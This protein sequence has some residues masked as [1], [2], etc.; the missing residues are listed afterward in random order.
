MRRWAVVLA[1]VLALGGC[2]KP[3]KETWQTLAPRPGSEVLVAVTM[4]QDSDAYAAGRQAAQDLAKRFLY[5]PRVVLVSECFVGARSKR[6][7]LKG[8]CSVLPPEI[9]FGGAT[10]GSFT[11]D[12]CY[13][14]DA[15]VL[16]GLGGEGLGVKVALEREL[17]AAGL[18][19]EDA[20][21]EIEG[22]LRAAGARL[23]R[24]IQ[25]ANDDRLLLV[26]ADAHTPKNGPLVEGIRQ[27]LGKQFPI[28]G[29]S[30]NKNAGQSYV[31]YQGR[32][33]SD[34]A[35]ALMLSGAFNVSLAG[36]QAKEAKAVVATA[37]AATAFAHKNLKGQPVIAL[38]FDCAGRKGK[39]DRLADELDAIQRVITKKVPIFG[40]YCAGEIGPADTADAS[41]GVLSYGVGWH[42]MLTLLG[43]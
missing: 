25:T 38:G 31:Y 41:P 43:R 2:A 18:S 15:V 40:C 37:E 17:G 16:L 6:R 9:V 29:G 19:T 12:G 34:A 4:A 11:R 23:A 35:L 5:A 14:R 13:D 20:W 21:Q 1:A 7:L 39:L 24:K 42:L 36:R 27:V 26:I 10:Y 22:R 32:M 28:T 8:I 3:L 30:V 33:F